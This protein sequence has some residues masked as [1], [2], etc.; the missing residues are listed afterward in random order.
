VKVSDNGRGFDPD[1]IPSG[2]MG[3]RNVAERI[4]RLGGVLTIDSAPGAGATITMQID[5]DETR[6]A[7]SEE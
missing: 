7:R 4:E 1:Q 6:P 5:L 3:L 2:G